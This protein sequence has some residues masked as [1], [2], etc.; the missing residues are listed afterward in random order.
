MAA[1]DGSEQ[2]GS[3][4]SP[5]PITETVRMPWASAAE[6][7]E[8]IVRPALAV[9]YRVAVGP[10]ADYYCPRFMRYERAGHFLPSWHWPAF[11]VPAVWAFYRKL[12]VAGIVFALLPLAGY[13]AVDALAPSFG[14]ADLAR[15]AALAGATWLAP[16]VV[17]GLFA[18]TLLYRQTR[19]LVR[20]AEAQTRRNHD[21]ATV[22][23]Q[24]KATSPVGAVVLGGVTVALQLALAA[25]ENGFSVGSG[26]ATSIATP[27]PAAPNG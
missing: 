18:N 3:G 15:Y 6:F 22:L 16:G 21:A 4:A 11:F 25:H 8:R 14:L 7:E 10:R 5:L 24:R 26:A 12:W 19:R 9:L 13:F 1:Q 23:A 2:S 27:P 20:L 17:G